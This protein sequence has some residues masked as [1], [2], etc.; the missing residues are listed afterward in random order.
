VATIIF[1]LFWCFV[2]RGAFALLDSF[3]RFLLWLA[4]L[5]VN[6]SYALHVFLFGARFC[7]FLLLLQ[8][9]G[10]GAG[11]SWEGHYAYEV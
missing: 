11:D 7:F 9:N 10:Y 6:T 1:A 5:S 4:D 3:F 2:G 8:S